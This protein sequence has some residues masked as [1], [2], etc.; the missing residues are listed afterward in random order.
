MQARWRGRNHAELAIYPG[1]VHGFIA[2]PSPQ[3]FAAIARQ[4]AFL[5]AVLGAPSSNHAAALRGAAS[6]AP[7]AIA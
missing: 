2:F 7:F 4:T 1:G 5:N 3:A 6:A